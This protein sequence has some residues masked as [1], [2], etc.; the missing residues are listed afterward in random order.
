MAAD[1]SVVIGVDVAEVAAQF[2]DRFLQWC[3]V[4][5]ISGV[6]EPALTVGAVHYV[7]GQS[8]NAAQVADFVAVMR[9]GVEP[10]RE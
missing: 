1:A 6:T 3:R 2:V 5:W 9:H 8:L 10:A 7:C 4:V